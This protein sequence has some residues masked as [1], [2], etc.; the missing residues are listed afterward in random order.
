MAGPWIAVAAAAPPRRR[1]PSRRGRV[2]TERAPIEA[3]DG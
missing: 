1:A 2:A 3:A